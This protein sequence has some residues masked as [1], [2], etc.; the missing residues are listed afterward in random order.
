[1][2]VSVCVYIALCVRCDFIFMNQSVCVRV[3]M[4]VCII[5]MYV[6]VT[7]T[8]L[9]KLIIQTLHLLHR[10]PQVSCTGRGAPTR[11]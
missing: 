6:R 4:R 2:Y 7:K 1:M 5:S 8:S 11:T 10:L 3:V 9:D